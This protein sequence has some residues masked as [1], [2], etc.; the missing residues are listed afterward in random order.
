[1]KLIIPKSTYPFIIILMVLFLVELFA[2]TP[3][4]WTQ[5]FNSDD[6][7]PFGSYLLMDLI[8]TDLFPNKEIEFKTVPVFNYPESSSSDP[9]KNYIFIT[10][11]LEMQKWDVDK[12]VKLAENGNQ[13]FISA[14]SISCSLADT[15]DL[16][17]TPNVMFSNLGKTVRVQKFE[18]Q[19]IS[20]NKSYKYEKAFDVVSIKNFNKDS[21][22]VLGRD[23]NKNI[24]FIKKQFGKGNIFFC[25]QPLSFTNYNVVEENNADY[26]AGAFSYL[27]NHSIVWDEY[28][29]PT[30]ALRN[31]SPL[32]Y[33]LTHPPLKL[34]FY[35]LFFSLVFLLLFQGKRQQRIV[36]IIQP[37]RNTSLEFIRTLGSLYYTKKNHKDIADKKLK[38]FK[39]FIRSRY[40][41]D[42]KKENIKELSSRSA[43][44]EKTLRM[45]FD[46]SKSIE[47]LTHLTQEGL[48]DFHSKIEYI[49]NNCK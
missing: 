49:Y 22:T 7:R 32:K 40:H 19:K 26:I 42:F 12:L 47:T 37:L 6:K 36:P 33:L 24:Q 25:C 5:N 28:Y 34:G 13:I 2:P 30:R 29:K 41:I 23:A 46:Q 27:P 11:S 4:D 18:N 21:L 38:Y 31:S 20:L 39:E 9:L 1:M 16:S 15:L 10:N 8:K 48:E 3:I 45:L 44:P 14:S 17:L 35:L 43:L